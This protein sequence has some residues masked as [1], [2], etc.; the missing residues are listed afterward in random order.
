MFELVNKESQILLRTANLAL[1]SL[2]VNWIDI[3]KVKVKDLII[4]GV[5]LFEQISQ[6]SL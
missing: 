5:K 1:R 3:D 4:G 6:I 2:I